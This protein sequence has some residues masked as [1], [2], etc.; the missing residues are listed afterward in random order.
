M[1]GFFLIF[2]YR[3]VFSHKFL[4]RR[5]CGLWVYL[6]LYVQILKRRPTK[7]MVMLFK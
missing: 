6:K 1:I 2:F 7:E 5:G 4:V 3:N